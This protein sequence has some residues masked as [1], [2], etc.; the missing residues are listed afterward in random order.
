MIINHSL[1]TISMKGGSG[2]GERESEVK[3]ERHW[4][5][6]VTL[7]KNRMLFSW[8]RGW[9]T[10]LSKISIITTMMKIIAFIL[11]ESKTVKVA[12]LLALTTGYLSVSILTYDVR[13]DGVKRMWK[14][15]IMEVI[16]SRHAVKHRRA[17][18]CCHELVLRTCARRIGC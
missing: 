17:A 9:K 11:V 8:E 12:V 4:V 5:L 7:R 16:R 15:E 3:G 6:L 2:R 1:M 10:I 13:D 18:C 14:G